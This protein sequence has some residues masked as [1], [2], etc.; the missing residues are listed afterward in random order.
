M[1]VV[2]VVVASIINHTSRQSALP[3]RAFSL[4]ARSRRRRRRAPASTPPNENKLSFSQHFKTISSYANDNVVLDEMRKMQQFASNRESR[5]TMSPNDVLSLSLSLLGGR[6]LS[7]YLPP[8][9]NLHLVVLIF[10][11]CLIIHLNARQLLGTH[12]H[13]DNDLGHLMKTHHRT[14][15]RASTHAHTHL[16][17]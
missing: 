14:H 11:N 15:N 1:V 16:P 10:Y 13:A 17:R 7:D 12:T 9:I 6:L 5:V 3:A 4:R 2:V 8:A